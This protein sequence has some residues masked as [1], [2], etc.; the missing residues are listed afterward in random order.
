MDPDT[1]NWLR[2]GHVLGFVL[3]IG[4]MVTVLQLLRVHGAVEGA[5]R[6]VLAR[7]ERKMAVV[8]DVGATLTMVCGFVTAL[9][10]T[11]NYFKTGAWLH[12]KLTLVA[13]VIIGVHGWT[14]AQ[15]RKFRK[16]QVRHVPP[17][18]MWVVLAATAAI[19]LLGAHHGLLRK[20]G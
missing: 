20:A 3:W 2:V 6:D 8:M 5:A 18:I 19:I 1:Y 9:G 14:R 12:I 13:L 4:A 10:G 15:V 16:G 17:A 11:V 7:H